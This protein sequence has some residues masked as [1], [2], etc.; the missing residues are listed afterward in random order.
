MMKPN[1]DT[2]M[3]QLRHFDDSIQ[4]PSTSD[5]QPIIFVMDVAEFGVKARQYCIVRYHCYSYLGVKLVV[6]GLHQAR[7]PA[8]PG[9]V[10]GE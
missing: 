7:S 9:S 3:K 2:V 1:Q 10:R 8:V 5:C 6:D 4:G